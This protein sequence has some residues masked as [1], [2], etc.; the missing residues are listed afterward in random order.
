MYHLFPDFQKMSVSGAAGSAHPSLPG[1][2]DSVRW[3][4]AA[5]CWLLA[6]ALAWG[7]S[8][9]LPF[10]GTGCR[11]GAGTG[12]REVDPPPKVDAQSP[13]RIPI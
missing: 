9:P 11:R 6:A 12:C 10:V 4:L 7:M 3:R 1:C 8:S 13:M 2:A 5:V